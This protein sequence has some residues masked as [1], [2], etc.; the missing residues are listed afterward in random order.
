MTDFFITI[1][2]DGTVTSTDI[3]DAIIKE[4]ARPGWEEAERLWEAGAIGS[5]ECLAIQM[6]LIEQPLERLI[7][8]A[9][10]VPL[11]PF[12]P[13]FIELLRENSIPFAVISDGF[14]I[15]INGALKR[16]GFNDIPVYA[17][18]LFGDGKKLK[19]VFTNSSDLCH[20]GTCKCKTA[21]SLACGLPIVHIGDGRSDFCLASRASYVFAKGK[22]ADYCGQKD[23][24]HFQ[25]TDFN[26][27]IN[28]IKALFTE[29]NLTAEVTQYNDLAGKAQPI[30]NMTN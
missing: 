8:H 26:T 25:F 2:F 23:I 3:T 30:W 21:R 9:C 4:F 12:F 5:M 10:T 6:S 20:S 15:I 17:N 16:A 22:L 29:T 27:V 19:T 13:D 1:D 14:S 7:E 28:G 11:D 18:G 24:Q